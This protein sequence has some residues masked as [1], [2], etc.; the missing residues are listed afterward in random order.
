MV[1]GLER[2]SAGIYGILL[3]VPVFVVGLVKDDLDLA[4]SFVLVIL[5][6]VWRT[7]DW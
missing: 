6:V 1:L 5:F 4:I 7:W 3:L 2:L